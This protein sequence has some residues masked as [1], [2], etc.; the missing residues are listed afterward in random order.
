MHCQ[1]KIICFS[2]QK[3]D[4]LN[5]YVNKFQLFLNKQVFRKKFAKKGSDTS[6]KQKTMQKRKN[7]LVTNTSLSA[8]EFYFYIF[9]PNSC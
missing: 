4:S 3:N 8:F 1:E 7:I 6:R 5:G 2:I 9:D